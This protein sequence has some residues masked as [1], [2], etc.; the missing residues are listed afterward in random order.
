MKEKILIVDDEE[1][2]RDICERFL[3]RE[4]YE[5]NTAKNYQ[6]AIN[7]IE[8]TR[9]DLI[10][11]DIRLEGKTGIDILEKI[12]EMNLDSIV[13]VFTGFPSLETASKALRLGAFEYLIKPI[14]KTI[15]LDTTK[16]ALRHKSLVEEKDRY[17]ANLEAIF[18]SVEEA[19]I[20]VDKDLRV[21]E[22]NKAV[23]N[24]CGINRETA[25]GGE[26]TSLQNSC[27]GNCLKILEETIKNKK[28]MEVDR[29]TC[30]LQNRAQ[31]VITIRTYPLFDIYN[32]FS[33]A[34]LVAKDETYVANLERDLGERRQFQN[35]I[36]KSKKMQEIYSLIEK[37]AQVPT[38]VL[39]TGESGTGKELV[40][41]ALHYRGNRG[42]KPLVK[43]SCSA[44]TDDL[45]ESEL[46]GHVK[47]AFTGAFEDK[48][49]RFQKAHEGTLL[50]DEIGDIS[51][52]MQLRLLRVLQ[53]QEFERVGSSTPIKVDV[54]F[55]AATNQDLLEKV[56]L[57][58]FR[59]DLY[60][61]L[62]V[63]RVALPPLRDRLEDIPLLVN[64][65]LKKFNGKLRKNVERVS[66]EV[67]RKFMNYPWPGNVREME[68]AVEHATIL[69][70]GY[71][72]EL[73]DLPR[74]CC[75]DTAANNNLKN[76]K[77]KSR[78][79]TLKALKEAG[80]NKA[81]AARLLGTSRHTLYKKIQKYN[82]AKPRE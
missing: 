20:S 39:I 40:A 69:C 37:L 9:F 71:C 80:W 82:I 78:E 24:L 4:G 46:F 13:V 21:I 63:M 18:K 7:G 57:G 22:I 34:V 29:L 81:K 14:N 25:I 50:L 28:P 68:H 72:I 3:S 56:K 76:F 65:F 59:E 11:V 1:S 10:F 67:L 30:G 6:E 51:H 31:Q 52:R 8:E 77:S 44:L 79:E 17:R 62:K 41:E 61:R 54:R 70:N 5:V 16:N 38:T 58:Q 66:D 26:L 53:T 75:M 45:L 60:Y 55:L 35:I 33:G 32:Q 36:G 48:I 64:H 12:K 42:D 2:I 43:L 49:G 23:Q 27:R 15:L 73:K 19:I 47:G 74:E